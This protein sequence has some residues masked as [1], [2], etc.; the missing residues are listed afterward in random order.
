MKKNSQ[1]KATQKPKAGEFY[2]IFSDY[3]LSLDNVMRIYK[4]KDNIAYY[5]RLDRLDGSE[6]SR[7]NFVQFP[8]CIENKLT[9]LEV[10][11][12]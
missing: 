6:L 5:K 3:C 11:L 7:W 10:E 1:K 4:V 12:L 8:E 9:P 2:R